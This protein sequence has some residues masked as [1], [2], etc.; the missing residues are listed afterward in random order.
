M[1]AATSASVKGGGGGGGGGA[2]GGGGGGGG[3]C[4]QPTD[5]AP[6]AIT[7]AQ[8]AAEDRA[9]NRARLWRRR[10][11][12][13]ISGYGAGGGAFGSAAGSATSENTRRG[14]V[15]FQSFLGAGRM[16]SLR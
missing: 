8:S 15:H 1:R 6:A 16:Y 2:A 12:V 4:L 10:D 3:S 9:W 14:T 7:I 5:I 13:G 11:I